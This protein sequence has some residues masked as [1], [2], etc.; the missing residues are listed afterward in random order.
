MGPKT[1]A[2]VLVAVGLVCVVVIVTCRFI[3]SRQAH[4]AGVPRS[5]WIEPVDFPGR[6]RVVA[7]L[8]IALVI[9]LAAFVGGMVY[10]TRAHRAAK[11][12]PAAATHTGR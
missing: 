8:A 7:L 2:A 3:I 6:G 10:S 11:A 1:T 5:W 12:P 4:R 9:G